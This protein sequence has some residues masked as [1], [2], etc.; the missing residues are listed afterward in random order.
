MGLWGPGAL[1][2]SCS[3]VYP[4]WE[5]RQSPPPSTYLP[6]WA[7][8][9]PAPLGL[10]AAILPTPWEQTVGQGGGGGRREEE[11]Q[12]VGK[13]AGLVPAQS[14]PSF[15]QPLDT[16]VELLLNAGDASVPGIRLQQ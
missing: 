4:S 16:L 10:R 8:D 6:N 2:L 3:C 11:G 13:R 14:H 12:T 7:W 5:P 15:P 1:G 9:D